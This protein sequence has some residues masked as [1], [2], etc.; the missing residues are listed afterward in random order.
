MLLSPLFRDNNHV[1][2]PT[3][4]RHGSRIDL[5]WLEG[6][7]FSSNYNTS[8][9]P[10]HEVMVSESLLIIETIKYMHLIPFISNNCLHLTLAHLTMLGEIDRVP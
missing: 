1:S 9:S 8:M 10:I 4:P 3:G 2:R 6:P 5:A 7:A